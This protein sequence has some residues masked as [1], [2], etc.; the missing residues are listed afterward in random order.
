MASLWIQSTPH[1]SIEAMVGVND[2]TVKY[3]VDLFK[4]SIEWDLK[5]NHENYKIGGDDII[6]EIDESK[7]GK[8][9]NHRGHRVEG[10]WVVGGVERTDERKMF[11][12]TVEDRSADTLL[13]VIARHVHPG[14][15]IYTDCWRGYSNDGLL[16]M[17]MLHAT[18]N[19]SEHFKDPETGV[20]T[21]TIEGTWRGIKLKV[22]SS[23]CTKTRITSHLL[24]FIW[25]RRNENDVWNR[26]IE[27]IRSVYENMELFYN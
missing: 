23:H 15:I 2:K 14:S 10:V 19:H 9:K 18:V 5:S 13:D 7:F 22:P 8:R 24:T 26:L 25:K 17:E 6:V 12:V 20:H 11:A 4:L 1:K 21:N 3:W 16:S 27:A